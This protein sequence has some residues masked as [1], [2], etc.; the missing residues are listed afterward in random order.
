VRIVLSELLV[1]CETMMLMTLK[2]LETQLSSGVGTGFE[3]G[4]I[5]TYLVNNR[6]TN[7]LC[8]VRSTQMTV[9]RNYVLCI[10]P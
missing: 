5:I 4:P 10:M 6:C 8:E 9:T 2:E 3:S 7:T 1:C